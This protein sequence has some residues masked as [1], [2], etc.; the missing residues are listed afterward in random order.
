MS[1]LQMPLDS[2]AVKKADDEFYANHPEYIQ[3]G[4]RVPLDPNNPADSAACAEWRASYIKNGGK[5]KESPPQKKPDDPVQHCGSEQPVA[6]LTVRW[7]K[8]EVTPDHN[9]TWPPATPPTDTIPDEAKVQLI[10]E[11]TNVPDGTSATM[12]IC[13]CATGAGVTGGAFN[14]LEVKGGKVVDPATG[15][16][17]EWVFE[18]KHKLWDPWDKPYYFF[19]CT[20]NFQGLSKST[21]KDFAAQQAACLRL[22]YWHCCTAESSTLSG[23]LPECNAVAGILNGVLFSKSLIQNLT[24]VG[25]PLAQYGSLLRNTYVFHQASHGNALKRSDNSSIPEGDPGE[26]KYT[27]ADWRSIVH[28]TPVPRFGD[29]QIANNADIP[30]APRYLFYAST[31]LTGW[32]P[33]FA[34]A[35]I[36]R[37]TRNVLAFRCSIPDSEAPVMARKFYTRWASYKLDPSKIPECFFK[38]GGDHYKK[39][40]P[41]LYGA[42]G[43]AISEGLSPLEIAGIAVA[44]VACGVLVGVAVWALLKK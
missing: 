8:A 34:N 24:T 13:H 23:V 43:G 16:A 3:N 17:L 14:N 10:G 44:A 41:I 22:K 32:E 1:Q 25:I 30:V 40:K 12:T 6:T 21:P 42:G 5:E 20:V 35:M 18:G 29:T 26:S 39:M 28:I 36:A 11:T 27:K 33:S 2:A 15:S 31:C 9:S 4:K 19:T 37:G 7:S 38:A